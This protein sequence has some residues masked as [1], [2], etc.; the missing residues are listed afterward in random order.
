MTKKLK[1]IYICLFIPFLIL[2]GLSILKIRHFEQYRQKIVLAKEIRKVLVQLF[3]DLSQGQN[4]P[5]LQVPADGGWHIDPE[6][7]IK[8][9]HLFH[10]IDGRRTLIADDIAAL[11]VRRQEQSPDILEIQIVARN[12]VSLVSNLRIRIR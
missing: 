8:E 3:M 11:R 10:L 12:S 4:E 2:L 7:M 1:I 5:L 6:Y 9:G